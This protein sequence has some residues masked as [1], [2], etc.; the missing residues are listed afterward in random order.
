LQK[1]FRAERRIAQ[2]SFARRKNSD[3][4]ELADAW[5][6]EIVSAARVPTARAAMHQSDCAA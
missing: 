2:S 1:H 5:L 3:F 6:F 4:N